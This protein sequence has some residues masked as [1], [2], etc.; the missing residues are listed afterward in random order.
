M[1]RTSVFKIQVRT[2]SDDKNALLLLE[3]GELVAILVELAD[4]SHGDARGNWVIET[5]FAPYP[6]GRPGAFP[7]AAHAADWISRNVCKWPFILGQD[8]VELR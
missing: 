3:G 6:G 4:E 5:T 1:S 7:S 8:I 2:G